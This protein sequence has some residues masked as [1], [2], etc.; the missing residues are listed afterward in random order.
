MDLYSLTLHEAKEMLERGDITA[1]QLTQSVLARMD[2]V[3]G[4]VKAYITR[5]DEGALTAA[6]QADDLRRAGKAGIL[7]GLPIS[8]K[9]VL[10][11]AD[12]KTT[13]G[14]K[15][16]ENFQPPYDATVVEK[17][18]NKGAVITGKV[19][20]D[21]FAMGSSNETC[22]FNVPTNPWNS[23]YVAGGSSGGSAASVAAGECLASLGSDTGGSIRQPASFCGTVG[24]KPTYGRVSR[25]GLVAYASSLDQVGPLTK[26]VTDC[27]LML[28]AIAGFDSHDSTSL[29][30]KVPTY[31]ESLIDGL[32]GIR[33]GI[34]KEYF[35]LGIRDDVNKV[36]MDS[37][38]KL[39]DAGAELVEISLPHTD[40]SLAA[41]YLIAMAEASSN[42]A[43]FDGVRYGFRAEDCD[44]LDKLY[45]KSR[46]LG[47][48]QEVKK[49]ILLGTYALSSGYYD[50]YYKK[51]SQVRSLVRNDFNE[52][53]A[54]CD[55]ICSAVSPVPAFEFGDMSKDPLAIYLSDILTIP[56]NLTGMPSIS[57]PGGLSTDG[58]PVGIQLQAPHLKEDLLFKAGWNLEKRVEMVGN[59]PKPEAQ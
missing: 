6:K 58:L 8:L 25:Y 14:S 50:A 42:L 49:R 45:S 56:A 21:E 15:M 57:V 37:L 11:T 52:A 28:E 23:K 30:Q 54:K 35:G 26:D 3:E 51:A 43:R 29:K 1:V 31:S 24:I 20:M 34:P 22:A 19:T 59:F 2:A 7:C 17:L 13:C 44:S 48:G 12:M 53:F 36:V 18:K 9:D 47:F 55:L 38:D 10:C 39:K 5:N 46:S 40:Y 33:I 41:Y 4:V 16:L 32:Q 27:A